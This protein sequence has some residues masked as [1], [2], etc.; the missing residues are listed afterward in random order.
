MPRSS[1]TAKGMHLEKT[2]RALLRGVSGR[3]SHFRGGVYLF[4]QSSLEVSTKRFFPRIGYNVIAAFT[5]V[6]LA[7]FLPVAT[8]TGANLQPTPVAEANQQTRLAFITKLCDGDSFEPK[9]QD[10][11]GY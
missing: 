6:G 10:T 11:S 5:Q 1:P 4:H 9:Q 2:S 8:V 3:L 7:V